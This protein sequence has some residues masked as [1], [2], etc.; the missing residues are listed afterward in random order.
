M[1]R[2]SGGEGQRLNL[3]CWKCTDPKNIR[4]EEIT[5]K[6]HQKIKKNTCVPFM[7]TTMPW[8]WNSWILL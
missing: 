2:S 1:A 4:I 7:Q 5:N 6:I 8:M 3:C